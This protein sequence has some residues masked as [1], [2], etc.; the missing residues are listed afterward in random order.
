MADSYLKVWEE[1]FS[2]R[3][4]GEYPP[5]DLI[6]FVKHNSKGARRRIL[7]I[8]C[9]PGANLPFLAKEAKLLCGLDFS[10]T[11]ISIANQKMARLSDLDPSM[12]DLRCGDISALPWGDST[13]DMVVDVFALYANPAAT[14]SQ[15]L[16]EVARVLC[17]G[18]LMY[19]KVWSASNVDHYK[20]GHPDLE[21]G[22]FS[23]SQAGP[24]ANM[25]I[26]HYFE[27]DEIKELWH[28]AGFEILDI[29][30]LNV[31]SVY[32]GF[33]WEE[34]QISAKMPI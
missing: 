3:E 13:F 20:L 26:S 25:G 21:K 30:Q 15:A 7:E 14:I 32:S 6:R 33:I 28:D 19:S 31:C 18:G 16:R 4:W 2:K 8:G 10:R 22:T 11:A 12:I 34:Y 24:C 9:G 5:E 29:Y 23:N 27:I 17:A 1:I